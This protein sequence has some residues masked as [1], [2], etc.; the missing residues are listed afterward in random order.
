MAA[1]HRISVIQWH[2]KELDIQYN[3]T[4]ACD[5]IRQAAA[6]GAELA[7]LPEYHINGM[8]PTDPRW[9]IQAG[10]TT[11]YLA[12]YQK[13]AKEL[14]ICIVPGTMIEKLTEPDQSTLFYNTAYFISNDG[15]ILGS[16]RKQNL[17]HPERPYLTSG[18]ECHVAIDTPIGRVGMLVCW[19]L[20]FPEPFRE[21]ILDGAQ[22]VIVPT[23]W[24]PH[25]ASLEARAYNRDCESLF[26]QST[27]ISRC[28]A[29]TCGIVFANAAGP[30]E[31]FLG[32]SQITLPLVGPIAKMGTEEGFIVADFDTA[33]IDAAERN[34][35]VRQDMKKEEWHY[36]YE[37]TG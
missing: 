1:T 5:Y 12:N 35:K 19:D 7:V 36:S 30:S 21:L 20:A 3:H 18:P 17:W 15:T 27:I 37:H 34:Y 10:E 28:F 29:N 2:I 14:Q 8:V 16:Y 22:I 13:L 25:D 33:I 24:T 9:A 4:K 26:V 32:L 31:D 11:Q 23:Y 6:Q